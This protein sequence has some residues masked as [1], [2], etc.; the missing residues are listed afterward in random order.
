MSA[1]IQVRT[2]VVKSTHW[3]PRDTGTATP[4][5]GSRVS[6]AHPES[7]YDCNTYQN[8]RGYDLPHCSYAFIAT[9]KALMLAF[10]FGRRRRY[11]ELGLLAMLRTQ[12]LGT[13]NL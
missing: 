12:T 1:L 6:P 7:W 2:P 4:T 3:I 13:P 9:R 10:Q 5:S 11:P 8:E